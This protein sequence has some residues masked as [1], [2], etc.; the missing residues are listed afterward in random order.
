[1]VETLDAYEVEDLKKSKE[2]LT[3]LQ[4]KIL[5]IYVRW[6]SHKSDSEKE[7]LSH[8]GCLAKQY[9]YTQ[10]LEYMEF[11]KKELCTD[12]KTRQFLRRTLGLIQITRKKL[13]NEPIPDKKNPEK[14]LE[15]IVRLVMGMRKQLKHNEPKSGKLEE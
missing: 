5:D 13:F 1:M 14:I 8:Y 2:E 7:V 10:M 12:E 15:Q 9:S 3:S 11:D 4:N 6:E